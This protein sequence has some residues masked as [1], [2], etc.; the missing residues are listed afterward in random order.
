MNA[1][2]ETMSCGEGRELLEWQGERLVDPFALLFFDK[3]QK[4]ASTMLSGCG[5]FLLLLLR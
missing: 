5:L 2:V 3:N 4:P 1:V